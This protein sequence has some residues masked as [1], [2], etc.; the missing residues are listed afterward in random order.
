MG[1]SWKLT[2]EFFGEKEWDWA[3]NIVWDN[4]VFLLLILEYA[5]DLT[6]NSSIITYLEYKT[7]CLWQQLHLGT[8]ES[9]LGIEVCSR[10]SLAFSLY[11]PFYSKVLIFN[12]SLKIYILRKINEKM[13]VKIAKYF[14][15]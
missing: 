13:M 6:D 10:C 8:M 9:H 12:L 3:T 4:L 15:N 7:D 2:Y 5:M 14:Q 1:I 11:L